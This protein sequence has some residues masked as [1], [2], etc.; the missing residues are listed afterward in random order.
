M[1]RIRTALGFWAVCRPVLA[2]D[3]SSRR[4]GF[5]CRTS[6]SF[7]AGFRSI[8]VSSAARRS[9]AMS[10]ALWYRF[11]GF[12]S[13]A[14]MQTCTTAGGTSGA[15]RWI[16]TGWACRCCIATATGLSPS[17]GTRPVSISYSTTP[18]E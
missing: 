3:L 17:K 18:V 12:F 15:R 2:F 10:R 8:R 9:D 1:F 14:F 13:I 5:G 16:G 7:R 11:S 6:W 4:W